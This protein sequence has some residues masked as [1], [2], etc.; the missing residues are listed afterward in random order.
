[1]LP[2]KMPIT[3][4][5]SQFQIPTCLLR[6]SLLP[7]LGSLAAVKT[8]GNS[9]VIWRGVMHLDPNILPQKILPPKNRHQKEPKI[10]NEKVVIMLTSLAKV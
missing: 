2:I 3:I 8:E 4:P 7:S 5:K 1:M 9:E 6:G 10:L